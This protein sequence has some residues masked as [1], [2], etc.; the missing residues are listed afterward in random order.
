[1]PSEWKPPLH[2]P[3]YCASR[4]PRLAQ[5]AS[6]A[7]RWGKAGTVE[8]QGRSP[9]Q[10]PSALLSA[11]GW[12]ELSYPVESMAKTIMYE[13]EDFKSEYYYAFPTPARSV[14]LLRG[15][16]QLFSSHQTL[17]PGLTLASPK[18]LSF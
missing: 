16:F 6:A 17:I 11:L 5:W 8:S 14:A 13:E 10:Q 12:L 1:M 7:A 18:C 3:G 4:P 15:L 9:S 2:R